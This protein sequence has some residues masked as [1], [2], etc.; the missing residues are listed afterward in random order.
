M[1][2]NKSVL[3]VIFSVSVFSLTYGLSSPLISL[4][5][6]DEGFSESLI[7]LNAAMHALGVFLIAPFLPALFKRFPP[8]ALML[9]SLTGIAF[10]FV[11]FSWTSL[12]FWFVLRIA[13]GVFTEIIMVQTETWLNDSTVEKARGKMM[14]IYTAGISS[15]FATGPV[16]LALSGSAGNLAFYIGAVIAL[17]AVL[18]LWRTGMPAVPSEEGPHTGLL[19]SLKLASLPIFATVLNAAIEVAGMNFLSLYAIKLGWQETDASLLI[20]VL[21]FG[22]ILLQLP[23]GWL[24]D[25][26]N[27]EHLISALS[28]LSA[29][30]A[31]VWP[32]ILT[33]H[34]LAYLVLFLWGGIFVGI[35]TVAITWVG[36]RFK[37]SQLAGIYAA[38]SVAWGVG[39]LLGPLLGGMAMTM[40]LHGLPYITGILCLLFAM[41]SLNTSFR[42]GSARTQG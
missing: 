8:L 14:A 33:L 16:I 23:I 29:L 6:L 9:V 22:A 30:T 24:A 20:S 38:M 27:R 39:A 32:H 35:Y 18:L 11:L 28:L 4:K 10:I 25:R 19:K 37:G 21:M 5:L 2:F 1:L 31:F 41:L 36:E 15:G 13:L 42:K 26:V 40:T 17:L 12:P 7:G 34:L 3:S